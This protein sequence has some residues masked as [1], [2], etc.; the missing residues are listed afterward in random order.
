M[1]EGEAPL[2]N[3]N[4]RD[5]TKWG[6]IDI[7]KPRKVVD[8][9]YLVF[10]ASCNICYL[11]ASRVGGWGATQLLTPEGA[12]SPRSGLRRSLMR[13]TNRRHVISGRNPERVHG[14]GPQ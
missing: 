2:P 4:T 6:A 12:G 9:A 10:V 11:S 8:I 13:S 1:R 5:L 3:I 7:P 14:G